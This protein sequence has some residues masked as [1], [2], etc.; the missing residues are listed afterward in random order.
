[1]SPGS[2]AKPE[3][4]AEMYE[5]CEYMCEEPKEAMDIEEGELSEEEEKKS[6]LGDERGGMQYI[7]RPSDK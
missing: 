1:M 4:G 2:V 6:D 7:C 5:T 3:I